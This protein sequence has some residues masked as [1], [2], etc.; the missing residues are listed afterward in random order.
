VVYLPWPAGGHLKVFVRLAIEHTSI[1]K[2]LTVELVPQTCW[3]SNVRSLVSRAE[4]DWIRWNAYSDAELRGLRWQG[5]H[6]AVDCHELWEYDDT[7]HVQ[8]LVRMV[9]LCPA[10][11]DVVHFG[12]ATDGGRG[13]E[14]LAH[15]RAVN[16]WTAKQARA[17]VQN[18]FAVWRARSKH[19]WSVDLMEL[20]SYDVSGRVISAG[21]RPALLK[22]RH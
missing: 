15:L 19:R 12:W 2:P 22:S 9:A 20:E 18:A 4:W 6:H 8:R 17:H 14:A 11:H 5:R 1:G 7:K 3:R 13:P 16:G 21:E 10:C